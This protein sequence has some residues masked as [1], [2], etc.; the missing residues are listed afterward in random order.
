MY[1]PYIVLWMQSTKEVSIWHGRE[2]CK[3]DTSFHVRLSAAKSS[4]QTESRSGKTAGRTTT[5]LAYRC[6]H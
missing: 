2:H 3:D 1:L 5:T 4:L 6:I